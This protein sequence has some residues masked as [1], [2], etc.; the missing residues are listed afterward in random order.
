MGRSSLQWYARGG[1]IARTGPYP[2]A[3]RA[4]RAIMGRDG[5]PVD[6]A[7]VWAERTPKKQRIV[8]ARAEA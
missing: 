3:E 1:G 2:S 5:L 6:G 8:V 7:F 4:A